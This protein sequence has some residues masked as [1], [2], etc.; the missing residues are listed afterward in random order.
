MHVDGTTKV[1]AL[2]YLILDVYDKLGIYN[3]KIQI[4]VNKTTPK[5]FLLKALEM[6]RHGM[7]S[8]VFCNDDVITKCLMSMGAT[9]EEAVDSVISG[10]YEYKACLLYTS[11]R[12]TPKKLYRRRG[13]CLQTVTAI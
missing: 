11:P 3:P 9:Y 2:S 8:I 12:I 10:C 1:N 4:K 6:I 13:L 5:D 7:S